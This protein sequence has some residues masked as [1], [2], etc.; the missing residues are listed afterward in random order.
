MWGMWLL[1][2]GFS[3]IIEMITVGFLVFWLGIGALLAMVV[4]FFTDNLIIQTA[5]FVISSILLI[6]LTKP[7][8]KK[9]IDKPTIPTNVE[10][11]LGKKGIVTKTINNTLGEGLVK[12]GGEVWSAKAENSNE[13]IEKGTDIEVLKIDGVKAIV[14]KV[15]VS[16]TILN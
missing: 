4:S 3:F 14:K 1:I 15:S 2:A 11:M 9:Y 12:V 10:K 8:V 13:I 5:V 16:E 6:F 7:L